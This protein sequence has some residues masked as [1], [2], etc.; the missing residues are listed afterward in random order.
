MLR[1][2]RNTAVALVD[3]AIS[4]IT[5][6]SGVT[7]ATLPNDISKASEFL[8]LGG[9]KSLE[10]LRAKILQRASDVVSI[11][12]ADLD[13][14]TRETVDTATAAKLIGKQTNTLRRWSSQ[15]APKPPISP[16]GKLGAELA[17][18]VDDLRAYARGQLFTPRAP[19][20]AQ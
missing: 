3:Q 14:E 13:Q 20:D 6:E 1:F 19:R 15:K 11:N 4:E 7:P 12:P 8:A 10:L 5:R 2:S 17:W 18:R 16:A 9:I